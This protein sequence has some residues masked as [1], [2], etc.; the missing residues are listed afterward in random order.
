MELSELKNQ[1]IGKIIHQ[2]DFEKGQDECF[3]IFDIK[4]YSSYHKDCYT[5]TL[6]SLKTL[7]KKNNLWSLIY[8]SNLRDFGFISSENQFNLRD[9]FSIKMI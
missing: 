1:F 6:Y 9:G 7:L 3:V 5:L 2:I 4:T 8:F